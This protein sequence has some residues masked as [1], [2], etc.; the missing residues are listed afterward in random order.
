[1]MALGGLMAM[2]AAVRAGQAGSQANSETQRTTTGLIFAGVRGS[3]VAIE[4]ATGKLA[5]HTHLAGGDFVNVIVSG[6]S[7]YGSTRGEI[8][9]LDP[10]TGTIRWHNELKGY[11]RSLM[12]MATAEV[13]GNQAAAIREKRRRD[14]EAAVFVPPGIY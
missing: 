3:V 1:M 11:G 5:W 4:Q 7:I 10:G 12:T 2:P 8:Y 14:A 9:C 13:S 6:G